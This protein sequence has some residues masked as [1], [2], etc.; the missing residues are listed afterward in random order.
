[1]IVMPWCAGLGVNVP[2]WFDV[3]VRY[4]LGQPYPWCTTKAIDG[5]FPAA[6]T[7]V[8]GYVPIGL[9]GL[10]YGVLTM[11]LVRGGSR[12]TSRAAAGLELTLGGHSIR[13]RQRTL[14]KML[15]LSFILYAICFIPGPMILTGF[16]YVAAQY[17]V[18]TLWLL[19]T[20]V[21]CGHATSPVNMTLILM[22]LGFFSSQVLPRVHWETMLW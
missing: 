18:V 12:I 11:K 9:M 7:T 3:G 13:E 19:R 10:L 15:L 21:I 20:L 8:G 2:V 16:P 4:A 1:M 14:T 5:P 6:W 17:Y 22:N